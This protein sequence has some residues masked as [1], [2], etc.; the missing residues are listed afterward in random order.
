[1]GANAV[2]HLPLDLEETDWLTML[3]I[4]GDIAQRLDAVIT[5]DDG[6]EVVW[7]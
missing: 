6:G 7:R 1:M 5:D 3:D 2:V 4:L